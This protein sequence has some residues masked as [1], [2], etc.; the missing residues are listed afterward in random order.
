MRKIDSI[1][2]SFR[3]LL[4]L[5]LFQCERKPKF[6]RFVKLPSISEIKNWNEAATWKTVWDMFRIDDTVNYKNFGIHFI[7]TRVFGDGYSTKAD[8]SWI[9]PDLHK[10][11]WNTAINFTKSFQMLLED[12]VIDV[13]CPWINFMKQKKGISSPEKEDL[14]S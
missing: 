14:I 1:L 4:R 13:L 8:A 7:V 3:L 6:L 2:S 10:T 5:G 12:V 11:D 9:N